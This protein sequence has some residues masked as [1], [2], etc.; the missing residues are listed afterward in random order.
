MLRCPILFFTVVM[1]KLFALLAAIF[2]AG[3]IVAEELE[4][5]ADAVENTRTPKQGYKFLEGGSVVVK[6]NGVTY[7]VNGQRVQ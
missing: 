1:K 2:L 4:V 5:K 6:K 3:M 7:S